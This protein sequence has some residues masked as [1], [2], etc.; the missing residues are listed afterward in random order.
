MANGE[1]RSELEA[2]IREFMDRYNAGFAGG[3]RDDLQAL[4]NLPVIYVSETEAQV[5]DRYPF[6]PV[7]LREATGF[8][9]PNTEF[10]IVHLEETRA[11]L[12]VEGTRHRE[13]DSVIESIDSFYILHKND[14]E[15][16]VS[17]FSGIRGAR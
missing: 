4:V 5:R 7:R 12:T 14:G 6:D 8:H 9:H 3:T 1:R 15:W 2:E 11:H 13:D 17:V 10:R 16:K